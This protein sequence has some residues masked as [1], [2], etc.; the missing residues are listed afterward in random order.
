MS[1]EYGAKREKIVM[2][3]KLLVTQV[4]NRYTRRIRDSGRD[5]L[6]SRL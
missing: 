4:S 1:G 2:N 5:D 3:T 6:E